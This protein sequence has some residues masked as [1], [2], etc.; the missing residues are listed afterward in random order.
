MK[1]NPIIKGQSNPSHD[2]VKNTQIKRGIAWPAM[3]VLQPSQ[4]VQKRSEEKPE[5]LLKGKSALPSEV[6]IPEKGDSSTLVE[7]IKP[8]RFSNES[9][10][11]A[12]KKNIPWAI[13]SLQQEEAYESS[14]P[15]YSLQEKAGVVQ[16]LS[17]TS[18]FSAPKPAA[19]KKEN[20]T[21]LPADL[22]EGVEN[23]SGMSMDDVKVHYNSDRPAGL[24]ALAYAQGTDIHLG[25]GQ[26]RHLPHEAWHVVQQKRGRVKPTFQIKER[27]VVNDARH[28]EPVI[29]RQVLSKI[30]T[31]LDEEK[32][33]WILDVVIGG[34]TPSPF[35][36]TMGAHS[37][38]W[39]AHL[40]SVRRMLINT[41]MQEGA[42]N[43]IQ[44]A[45]K[46]LNSPLLT[47]KNLL[48]QQHNQKLE[49]A[50]KTLRQNIA[51]LQNEL[52]NLQISPAF[53][54]QLIR[55]LINSYLTFINYLPA[56]TVKG[57]NPEGQGEGSARGDINTF[58]YVF[59][60]TQY[61]SKHKDRGN[62]ELLTE[63]IKT[64]S[65]KGI[66]SAIKFGA[67]KKFRYDV[68][69]E[70]LELR[71]ALI[72]SLWTLFAVETPAIFSG[73]KNEKDTLLVWRLSLNNFLN[74]ISRAYPY[75]YD[76]TEMQ[77]KKS[78]IEGLQYLLTL[79]GRPST[80]EDLYSKLVQPV[81][82]EE[83]EIRETNDEVSPAD[84][85]QSGSGFMV[86]ILL[87]ED[88]PSYN[89]N[90]IGD[91]QMIGRT[92]S[93]FSGTM[94]AHTTAWVAHLDA[95]RNIL[96]GKKV[97][98]AI[99]SLQYKAQEAMQDEALQLSNVI[100]EKH[101]IF[102][103]GSYNVLKE[104]NTQVA[105]QKDKMLDEQVNYLEEYVRNYLDFVNLLP[106]STIEHGGIPGGKTEGRHRSFL[107]NYEQLGV[108]VFGNQAQED[109][110]AI[111]QEHLMGLFDR[112]AL[113]GF[114]T[115][116]TKPDRIEKHVDFDQSHPLRE[117]IYSTKVISNQSEIA[118]NRFF[119]TILEAYP[120]AV[121]DSGL[122]EKL[123]PLKKISEA[124][125]QDIRTKE[126][127]E[128]KL[129]LEQ[130]D[131]LI[132]AIKKAAFGT[133]SLV[134]PN[135][136][137]HI[138]IRIG[139]IELLRF[140]NERSVS[141]ICDALNIPNGIRI[142]YKD[143]FPD[144]FSD[145]SLPPVQIE[146]L[147]AS[148]FVPYHDRLERS[149]I[150]SESENHSI[151]LPIQNIIPKIQLE[152][153]NLLNSS[154]IAQ[155]SFLTQLPFILPRGTSLSFTLTF[156][157]NIDFPDNSTTY[158]I[159]GRR[160]QHES[161][162]PVN[163]LMPP[164]QEP[165]LNVTKKRDI[166]K[167]NDLQPIQQPKKKIKKIEVAWWNGSEVF[168]FNIPVAPAKNLPDKSMH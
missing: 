15:N 125:V 51:N 59:A 73:G 166:E 154:L 113:K 53:G 137:L 159:T 63:E 111:L 6:S 44:L 67:L 101:Q 23:L 20:S 42:G 126:E 132:N 69:N 149:L 62:Q 161:L 43:L 75:A 127:G 76:F 3:P 96:I 5:I 114:T 81:H 102:L 19:Q 61:A 31:A 46:E 130:P 28:P 41:E 163:Y 4:I 34:R 142:I 70:K 107:L 32:I 66:Q 153:E 47:L 18:P 168:N 45:E 8:G 52:T 97:L 105:G 103:V 135:E 22:K 91:V 57:G 141:I 72:E 26:E 49:Q 120:R 7:A 38:S 40:D 39:I 131:N 17:P 2:I 92:K 108:R 117:K 106:L 36:G 95:V 35:A 60:R 146:H 68:A 80:A 143:R 112:S 128:L 158:L 133:E 165:E 86:T 78:Q 29:Q 144:D 37:T 129:I 93:P 156:T 140:A 100:N 14:I 11:P 122:I 33:T 134:T 98:E 99:T 104:L 16:K 138:R 147:G 139:Q 87:A 1:S 30:E 82:D 77:T 167:E 25:S 88:E 58:E 116:I 24:H 162:A 10:L 12:Q 155:D 115:D 150:G 148:H 123:D 13:T 21:G 85:K 27:T 64:L 79:K 118:R 145:H 164:Q 48:D 136:L 110:Q 152:M 151:M 83:S 160:P 157:D 89:S 55:H 9:E 54:K 121:T 90:L 71:K 50:E 124:S 74:T 65:N 84:F 119:K 56:S 94:G 109:H